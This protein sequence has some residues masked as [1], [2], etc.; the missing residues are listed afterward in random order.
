[1]LIFLVPKSKRYIMVDP[2]SVIFLVVSLRILV[3]PTMIN[4]SGDDSCAG[5]NG[6][7]RDD[8]REAAKIG[9]YLGDTDESNSGNYPP[10]KVSSRRVWSFQ[11]S[12]CLPNT[13]VA[14]GISE[15]CRCFVRYS[16]VGWS[17]FL[18]VQEELVVRITMFSSLA[19]N[20]LHPGITW[21]RCIHFPSVLWTCAR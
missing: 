12:K 11:N 4:G 15:G 1:M 3:S 14:R 2:P 18:N 21:I 5:G 6:A 10:W 20:E 7:Q 16:G 9:T 13:F 8:Q 19:F 17:W